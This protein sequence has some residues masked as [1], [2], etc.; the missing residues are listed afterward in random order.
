MFRRIMKHSNAIG[1]SSVGRYIP[2]RTAFCMRASF[3][4]S[5]MAGFVTHGRSLWFVTVKM[6]ARKLRVMSQLLRSSSKVID[7]LNGKRIRGLWSQEVRWF[8]GGCFRN[9]CGFDAKTV[10]YIWKPSL[11]RR[12]LKDTTYIYIQY[13]QGSIIYMKAANECRQL[14]HRC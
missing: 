6:E 8:F 9:L 7:K 13:L 4:W 14:N 10:E 3:S 5:M 11:Y 12:N 2:I 1:S